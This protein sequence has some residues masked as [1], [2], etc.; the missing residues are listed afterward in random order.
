MSFI[1]ALVMSFLASSGDLMSPT[2]SR[3][4]STDGL[5]SFELGPEWIKADRA[6]PIYRATVDR[7]TLANPEAANGLN[8]IWIPFT[9][10]WLNRDIAEK[11][12]ELSILRLGDDYGGPSMG[13]NARDLERNLLKSIPATSRASARVVKLSIGDAVELTESWKFV[14]HEK[15]MTGNT[16]SYYVKVGTSF[17]W[18]T[19]DDGS[20][21]VEKD[22]KRFEE[23][24]RTF[25]IHRNPFDKKPPTAL[26]LATIKIFRSLNLGLMLYAA[27]N[28]DTVPAAQSSKEV[29]H[30]LTP[31][32]KHPEDAESVRA[33]GRGIECNLDLIGKP[34]GD[35]DEDADKVVMLYEAKAWPDGRRCVGFLSGRCSLVDAD[36][37]KVL[38]GRM[39]HYQRYK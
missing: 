12:L 35:L 3:Y 32:L 31:Y 15:Q 34:L 18:L 13:Q 26:Q 28:D 17:R 20:R 36:E 4:F 38:A 2:V 24:A 29:L 27:D 23:I 33:N 9:M 14:R 6:N 39:K 19:L 16:I 22:R 5:F 30:A 1:V 10:C 8:R 11:E 37:W 25:K 7:V 21:D